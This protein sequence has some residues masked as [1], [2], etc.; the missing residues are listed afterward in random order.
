MEYNLSMVSKENIEYIKYVLQNNT[1]KTFIN[2][3][4]LTKTI[5]YFF[6]I[7]SNKTYLLFFALIS[8]FKI[9]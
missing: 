1:A 3:S 4:L 2:Q 6:N 8:I 9:A 5:G 7:F